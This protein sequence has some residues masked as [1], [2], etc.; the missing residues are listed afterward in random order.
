MKISMDK[1]CI[2]FSNAFDFIEKE[3][4]GATEYHSMRVA[5][6]CAKIAKYLGYK[7]EAIAGIATCA[8]FH[9][10]ALT[11]YHLSLTDSPERGRNMRLHCEKGQENISWLPFASSVDGF[12]L[13]H[14]E[15]GNGSGPFKKKEGEYPFEAALIAAVDAVDVDYKLQ[16]ISKDELE[17]LKA[18]VKEY[19][20]EYSTEKAVDVFLEVLDYDVLESL[21]NENIRKTL[22]DTFPKW[23]ID[24]DNHGVL[25][26]AD[27]LS[28]VID[29]KSEFT[30]V[31]TSQIANRAWVMANHYGYDEKE[32]AGLFLAC[33]LHDI[34]KVAIPIDI[35]EKPGRLNDEEFQIIQNH[36]GQTYTMLSNIPN[37]EPLLSWASN[38][39][40]K[41]NGKGYPQ[42]KVSDEL[43]FNSRL[44]AC[45]DI[46]QA[47]C[48]PRPYHDARTHEQTMEILY[49]MASK[50]QVDSDIVKDL[51]EVMAI[52]SM[53]EIPS[54]IDHTLS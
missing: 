8:L 16:N 54:P 49:D 29:Y 48:E 9:D 15:R 5:A 22:D 17:N 27:F 41:L 32:K 13:Y 11:E 1:L 39:H 12:I 4:L 38:H 34:G 7:E 37:F 14:H 51:D 46:Y 25:Y 23:E 42:K 21:R 43:D 52:Y 20:N 36:I 3:Q 50:E 18:E 31:H 30:R 2:V 45:L 47:V 10:N 53:K 26:A 28:H 44:V 24:V 33:S 40:E 6:L 19:A 35:L